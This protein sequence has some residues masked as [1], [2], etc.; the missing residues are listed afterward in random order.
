[1]SKEFHLTGKEKRRLMKKGMEPCKIEE[2]INEILICKKTLLENEDI[3]VYVFIK[4]PLLEI[5]DIR[6]VKNA[7]LIP[8][9][10]YFKKICLKKDELKY[11]NRILG[12][13][14]EV[15]ETQYAQVKLLELK[16]K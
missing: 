15:I 3:I 14:F 8:E 2:F 1:M 9:E 10:R 4:S 12:K 11:S 13:C 6:K 5:V 7:R 16:K